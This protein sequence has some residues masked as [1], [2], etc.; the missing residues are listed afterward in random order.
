MQSI[1]LSRSNYVTSY[2]FDCIL[3]SMCR[4]AFHRFF[5]TMKMVTTQYKRNTKDENSLEIYFKM[6]PSSHTRLEKERVTLRFPQLLMAE[7]RKVAEVKNMSMN[8]YLEQALVEKLKVDSLNTQINEDIE[9]Y[10]LLKNESVDELACLKQ[11]LQKTL[12]DNEK[13]KKTVEEYRSTN[14]GRE[15]ESFELF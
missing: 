8:L 9:T 1:C 2:N 3:L 15:F 13:L 5:R 10:S 6:N 11:L 4:T 14:N 12:H 7:A